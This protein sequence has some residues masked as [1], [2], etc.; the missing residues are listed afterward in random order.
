MSRNKYNK[1]S[2]YMKKNFNLNKGYTED[3]SQCGV[4]PCSQIGKLSN[5]KASALPMLI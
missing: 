4:N 3:L 5:V 2:I 1:N